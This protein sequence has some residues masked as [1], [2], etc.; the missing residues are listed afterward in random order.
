LNNPADHRKL[1]DDFSDAYIT[2]VLSSYSRILPLQNHHH[3]V[4]G[5]DEVW[6]VRELRKLGKPFSLVRSKIDTDIE[7]AIYNG[8]DQEMIIPEI[9][10]KIKNALHASPEPRTLSKKMKKKS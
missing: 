1:F 10:R 7:S 3:N 4:L 5:E 9:K 8:K 6:L 2:L